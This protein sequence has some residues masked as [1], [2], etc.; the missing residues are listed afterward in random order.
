MQELAKTAKNFIS[1]ASI[2]LLCSVPIGFLWVLSVC[3]CACVPN[4]KQRHQVM[5]W[6]WLYCFTVLSLAFPLVLCLSFS[7]HLWCKHTLHN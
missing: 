2:R 6:Q 7:V 1:G 5:K 4:T 3:V